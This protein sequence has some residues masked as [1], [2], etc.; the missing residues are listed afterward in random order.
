MKTD[1]DGIP[2]NLCRTPAFMGHEEVVLP[3]L[4]L[5]SSEWGKN[6][7]IGTFRHCL[8]GKFRPND[9]SNT[10]IVGYTS[11][12]HPVMLDMNSI[13]VGKYGDEWTRIPEVTAALDALNRE[14]AFFSEESSA[15][16]QDAFVRR[17]RL[18]ARSML[19]NFHPEANVEA[20][21]T[22]T[23]TAAEV[24]A[25]F[26]RHSIGGP[27]YERIY[28]DYCRSWECHRLYGDDEQFSLGNAIWL[29]QKGVVRAWTRVTYVPK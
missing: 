6:D 9:L 21:A 17:C 24:L 22:Q 3:M 27:H 26:F 29:E 16:F 7:A 5:G 15:P 10:A 4:V 18:I 19:R 1:L 25:A 11:G 28:G 2:V 23:S 13:F 14:Y 8:N 12:V 20:E